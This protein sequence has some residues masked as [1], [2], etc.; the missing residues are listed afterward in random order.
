[1]ISV[2]GKKVRKRADVSLVERGLARDLREAQALILAGKVWCAEVRVEKPGQSLA[3][4]AP[5]RSEDAS[6]PY[7]SRGGFKLAGALDSLGIGVSG[8]ICLDI[9][10]STGGFT[11]CLLQRGAARVLALDVGKGQL[12]WKLCRDPR[13]IRLEGINARYLRCED[14]PEVPGLIVVDV[15]FIG[16][17]LVLP[18]VMESCPGAGPELLVL[19][20]PQFEVPRHKVDR[21]GLVTDA[22]ARQEAVHRV[23]AVITEGGWRVAGEVESCLPGAEGNREVFLYAVQKSEKGI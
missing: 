23:R 8:K 4:D 13:V 1:M 21:G 19:V 9:G 22:A 17:A 20:K 10:A 7:V 14:L 15:S 5:L 11:D 12:D 18:A 16:L 3:A 6:R 2:A